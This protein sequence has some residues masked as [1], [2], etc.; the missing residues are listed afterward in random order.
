MTS[1]YFVYTED[2]EQWRSAIKQQLEHELD[3]RVREALETPPPTA[4]SVIE[5]PPSPSTK[6]HGSHRLRPYSKISY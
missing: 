6:I 4:R 2:E 3:K 1:S 5:T